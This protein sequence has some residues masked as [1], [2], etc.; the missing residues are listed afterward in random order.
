MTSHWI[1]FFAAAGL[2]AVTPGPGLL[3][4]AARTVS[5]GR[6]EG[7]LSIA[8]T[9]AGGLVHVTAGA[10]G[11]SALLMASAEAFAI[12]KFA[13]AIYLIWLGIKTFRAP[14]TPPSQ[15]PQPSGRAFRDGVAVEAF[16]PKTAA[17]FLAFIPQF[18]EPFHPVATQ[19]LLLG[20]VSVTLN[21]LADV[22]VSL[23][24]SHAR[25]STLRRP[26][27]VRW[28]HRISGSVLCG[29]G[30]SLLVARRN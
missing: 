23:V 9:A 2:L 12:L 25:E 20:A 21:S 15:L 5:G 8:G 24:A 6:R 14:V 13:G 26:S 29:L 11:V 30:V 4:V 18:I 3:Y 1:V 28:F 7:L 27:L 16:N 10:F 17:F 19:F 22:A